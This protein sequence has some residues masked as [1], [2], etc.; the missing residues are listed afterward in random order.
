M[1]MAGPGRPGPAPKVKKQKTLDPDAAIV[2]ATGAATAIAQALPTAKEKEAA[3]KRAERLKVK[4]EGPRKKYPKPADFK[5][6]PLAK[7]LNGFA[8]KAAGV[9]G[10][11]AAASSML[12]ESWMAVVDYYFVGP[13]HP[14]IIA[15][16]A[17]A[18]FA[19]VAWHVKSQSKAGAAPAKGPGSPAGV[20][21]PRCFQ[22]GNA[23]PSQEAVAMHVLEAHK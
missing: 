7:A 4:E 20:Q 12:G 16:I 23:F 18:Q 10:S 1:I 14:M 17:T 9:P 22:C 5:D 11:N 19:A 15:S 2:E 8:D 13:D 21:D 6:H 3:R